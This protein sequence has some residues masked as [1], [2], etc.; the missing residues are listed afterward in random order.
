VVTAIGGI[1]CG[2]GL[3]VAYPIVLIG[4]AYTF[5]VLNNEPVTPAA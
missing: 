4:Q 5:R 3:L 2:V 1:V